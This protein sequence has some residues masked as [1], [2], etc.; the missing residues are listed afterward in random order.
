[1]SKKTD[2]PEY[3]AAEEKQHKLS[4]KTRRNFRFGTNMLAVIAVVIVLFV[5][6]NLVLENFSTDLTVDLTAEKL[7]SIS[8]V[9]KDSLNSLEKDVEIYALY[10]RVRG[11]ADSSRIAVIKVLDLYD[12]F[13]K[14][15]VSYVDTDANPSFVLDTVGKANASAYSAGDYIV[16]CGEKTRRIAENDMYATTTQTVNMYS[17]D[18]QSGM[19]VERKVTTAILYVAADVSPIVYYMT[20]HGEESL[21]D[22]SELF[23]YVEGLGADIR[24][25]DMT[26]ITEMPEDAAVAIFMGPKYDLTSFERTFLQQWLEQSGG[27]LAVCVNPLQSG[28]EFANL[29]SLLRD[30]FGL[31]LNNDTVSDDSM[32]IAS[33]SNPFYFLGTS[34]SNGPIENSSVYQT[35]VFTSRSINVLNIDESA[36]GINHYPIIQTYSSAVSTSMIGGQKSDPGTFTVAAAAKNLNFNDV[37]RAV[38]F[39]ST[40]GLTDTFYANYGIYTQRTMSIFAMSVD[41]M[42]DSYGDNAGSEIAAKNY[43]SYQLVTTST[44]SNV[45][46]IIATVV[47][48]VIIILVGVIVWL[49]RRHL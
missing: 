46:G 40:L 34:V 1:M 36:T 14:V 3:V 22:F 11:E 33:A 5:V 12:Q 19:Q 32:Q 21:S 45:L 23:T 20:G 17:Y 49:K 43:S 27:Q 39:G 4:Q 48:P 35:P 2:S 38:V 8:D 16:K 31:E 6:V 10:D 15:T 28:T 7:Y 42:I 24:E 37:S 18:V 30:M 13:D 29:N 25:L 9:T 41:W 44:R 47:I 26:E